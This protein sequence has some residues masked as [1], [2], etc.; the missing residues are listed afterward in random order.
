M[1]L[2]PDPNASATFKM[3]AAEVRADLSSGMENLELWFCLFK[4]A[5]RNVLPKKN[6]T[7]IKGAM[8]CYFSPI[9]TNYMHKCDAVV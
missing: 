6:G 2:D 9:Q 1:A 8:S 4:A 5:L 7:S 3:S